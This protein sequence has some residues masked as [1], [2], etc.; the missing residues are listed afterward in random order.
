MTPSCGTVNTKEGRDDIQ[1]DL[2]SLEK[3]AHVNRMRFNK[4]KCKVLYLSQV[5]PR[6]EYR[7]GEQLIE[8]S[9][10]EKDLGVLMDERLD[11]T[12]Q[13]VLAIQ[14]TKCTLG[15]IKRG[16]TSRS[17][18]AIVPL[19]SALVRSHLEYCIQAWGPQ[20]KKDVDKLE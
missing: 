2:D 8:S 11:L 13:C 14:K 18:E 10:A 6:Q 15:C 7:L 12:Q 3:W 4:P 5:N 16:V 19:F 20:H 1:R 9:P 17:R